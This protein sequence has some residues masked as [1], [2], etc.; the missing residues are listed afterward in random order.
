M[1]WAHDLGKD[2]APH[3]ED[4]ADDLLE[5]EDEDGSALCEDCGAE[6]VAAETYLDALEDENPGLEDNED[7]LEWREARLDEHSR[8]CSRCSSGTQVVFH[9]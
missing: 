3:W 6:T 7:Y 9:G 4:T 8:V 1:A 2:E 5:D